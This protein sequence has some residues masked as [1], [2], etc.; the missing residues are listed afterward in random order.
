MATIM[1]AGVNAAIENYVL[2]NSTHE[3]E[4]L[5][6]Q[7]RFLERW[8]EQFM[9]SAGLEPGMRVLDL[10]CGMGDVSLLAARLVGRTGTVT[11]IDRDGIVLEKARERTR[12][13]EYGA[14]VD[15]IQTEFLDSAARRNSMQLSDG[16]YCSISLTRSRLSCMLPRSFVLAES[17]SFTRWISQTG[18]EAI[19]TGHFSKGC[20]S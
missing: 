2:G 10:G 6:L 4:R 14:N 11:G 8:T 7:A 15:F 20:K 9:L 5:K 1:N 17:L 13:H 18:F 19:R 12:S 16:M 3:Q